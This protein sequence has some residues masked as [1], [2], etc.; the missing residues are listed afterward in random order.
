MRVILVSLFGV[1]ESVDHITNDMMDN[2]G[3]TF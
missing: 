3:V 2:F 1:H